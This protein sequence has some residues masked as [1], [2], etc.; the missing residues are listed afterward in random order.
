MIVL[1]VVVLLARRGDGATCVVAARAT[2][3]A[4][5]SWRA[6]T[7]SCSASC[8]SS[9]QAPDV[10]AVADRGRRGRAAADDPAGA[11][12]GRA[13]AR[14]ELHGA[15]PRVPGLR[16]RR[17]LALLLWSFTG[18]RTSAHYLGPYG[19]ILRGS[20]SP[21]ATTTAVVSAI[22][23]DFR[24]FDTLGEEF[25]LF[26]AVVGVACLLRELRGERDSGPTTTRAAA[27]CARRASARAAWSALALV[28]PTL[29]VGLYVV[30]H[31]HHDAGRRLPGRR[32]P[33][34]ALLLVYLAGEYAD[35]AAGRGR[36]PWSSSPRRSGRR[37]S[38]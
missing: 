29:L 26:A 13:G 10:G 9:S 14:N 36:W 34:T 5:R 25:I 6:S 8:S 12:E 7:A 32:D 22:N 19:D 35:A 37:R 31:G 28:G 18:C 4:R 11:G 3:C 38:C 24:G 30:I 21:S 1:E 16:R 2:P 23:F 15:A 27:G 17:W 33:A 20:R